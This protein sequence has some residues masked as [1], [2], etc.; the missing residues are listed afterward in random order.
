MSNDQ[1][2][3]FGEQDEQER[4]CRVCGEPF[5]AEQ[6]HHRLCKGCWTRRQKRR[7]LPQERS[8]QWFERLYGRR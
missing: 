6:D 4:S 7:R 2:D 1:M 8:V 3:L 5:E